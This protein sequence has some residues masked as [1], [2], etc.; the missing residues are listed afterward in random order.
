MVTRRTVV[1]LATLAEFLPKPPDAWKSTAEILADF[2]AL[3]HSIELQYPRS[4][5]LDAVSRGTAVHRYLEAEV[6]H[7]LLHDAR[8]SDSKIGGLIIADESHRM[9]SIDFGPIDLDPPECSVCGDTGVDFDIDGRPYR[10]CCTPGPKH[11]ER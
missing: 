3:L 6:S 1:E 8:S 9:M 10:C 5:Y 2:E 7:S 11:F 4:A